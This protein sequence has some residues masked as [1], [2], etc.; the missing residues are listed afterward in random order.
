MHGSFTGFRHLPLPFQTFLNA[1]T[2]FRIQV[3][4]LCSAPPNWLLLPGLRHRSLSL[5]PPTAPLCSLSS[6][7]A[8]FKFTFTKKP[9]QKFLPHS[10]TVTLTNSP[11]W[12]P[13]H[14]TLV[15]LCRFTVSLLVVIVCLI[16]GRPP[17][18]PHQ[19]LF[20]ML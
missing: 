13:I 11:E 12:L 14:L 2:S 7:K 1:L 18:A 20:T 8:C 9:V 4:V 3:H 15:G 17:H 5:P 19:R 16:M 6:S 10:S